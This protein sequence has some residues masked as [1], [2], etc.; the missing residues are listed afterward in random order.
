MRGIR[1]ASNKWTVTKVPAS[2]LVAAE[3][4]SPLHLC[5]EGV[6]AA[7]YALWRA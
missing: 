7:D 2:S 1:D 6:V 3:L 4:G 5:A